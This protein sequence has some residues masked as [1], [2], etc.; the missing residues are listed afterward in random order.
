MSYTDKDI[1][2][3]K[4]KSQLSGVIDINYKRYNNEYMEA[5]FERERAFR[6]SKKAEA[7]KQELDAAKEASAE[8]HS[9]MKGRKSFKI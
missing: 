1:E 2:L 6:E 7:K 8:L 9:I 3:E 4:M 5:A